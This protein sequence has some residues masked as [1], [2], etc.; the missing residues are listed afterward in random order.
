MKILLF[1]FDYELFLGRR[2]GSVQK[3]L[4]EPTNRL[5]R[6]FDTYHISHAIFFVDT[7]Y[8]IRLKEA[9]GL[10]EKARVDWERIREQLTEIV[11]SGHYVFPHLHPHWL[12]AKYL[13]ASNQWTLADTTK[14]RFDS[15]SKTERDKIFDQS[16]KILPDIM[17]SVVSY[18]YTDGFRAGGWS[19]QPFETFRPYFEKYDIKYDF[20]LLP[21]KYQFTDAQFYDYR[22]CPDKPVYRFSNQV[23]K[24]DRNGTFTEIAITTLRYPAMVEKMDNYWQ[25]ILWRLNNRSS[26]D[27]HGVISKTLKGFEESEEQNGHLQRASIELLNWITWRL[28]RKNIEKNNYMHFIS[29]PKM[30]SEHNFYMLDK[31]LSW[32]YTKYSIETDFNKALEI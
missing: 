14:Y 24:E 1:T 25:K 17:G 30:L 10:Y 21:G 9:A 4:L 29:H 15:L 26:G 19:L 12:D 31:L 32:V 7:M 6:I 20:S 8:L 23:E 3:C 2:S 16:M 5:L 13:A 22:V 27:G 11:N 28:Y 18:H